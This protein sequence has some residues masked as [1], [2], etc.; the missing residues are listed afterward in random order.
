MVHST[1]K[2][3]AIVTGASRGIGF[4]ITR[5]LGLDGCQ[6]MLMATGP[7]EKYDADIVIVVCMTN[8]FH[9][10]AR[11]DHIMGFNSFIV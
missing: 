11:A 10:I 5:R 6:V 7:R 8:H 1:M 3:T 2:R 4:A 9:M